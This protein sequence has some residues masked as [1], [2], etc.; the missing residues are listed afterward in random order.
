MQS[1]SLSVQRGARVS[2]DME[3]VAYRIQ[4]AVCRS[5]TLAYGTDTMPR[6]NERAMWRETVAERGAASALHSIARAV[7]HISLCARHCPAPF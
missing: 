7:K 2:Y 4:N 6:C 1:I 3:A 5:V